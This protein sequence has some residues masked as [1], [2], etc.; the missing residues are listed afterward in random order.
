MRY[1]S[2]FPAFRRERVLAARGSAATC[3]DNKADGIADDNGNDTT[4]EGTANENEPD[5]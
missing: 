5:S 3:K 1:T 2:S 4:S